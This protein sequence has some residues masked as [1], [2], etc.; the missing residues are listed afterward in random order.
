MYPK[1]SIADPCRH[2]SHLG[3]P[4]RCCSN[5]ASHDTPSTA[6]PDPH[7]HAW[8]NDAPTLLPALILRDG[9]RVRSLDE[10][11]L[12]DR[13]PHVRLVAILKLDAVAVALVPQLEDLAGAVAVGIRGG[14]PAY[15]RLHGVTHLEAQ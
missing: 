5:H 7:A 6:D 8:K 12:V 3:S 14:V 1:S 11:V 4:L 2:W 15:P 13:A 9:R 10:D